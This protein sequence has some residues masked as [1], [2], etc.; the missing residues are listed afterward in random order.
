MRKTAFIVSVAFVLVTLASCGGGVKH[1]PFP[2]QPQPEPPGASIAITPASD[3]FFVQPGWAIEFRAEVTGVS[4]LSGLQWSVSGGEVLS[5]EGTTLVWRPPNVP[6]GA[7]FTITASVGGESASYEV[8]VQTILPPPWRD[9]IVLWV[10]D[11]ANESNVIMPGATVQFGYTSPEEL[12][13]PSWRASFGSFTGSAYTAPDVL[14]ATEVIVTLLN[15]GVPAASKVFLLDNEELSFQSS[16]E[17][18]YVL[19]SHEEYEGK[20][21]GSYI[22]YRGILFSLGVSAVFRYMP[23]LENWDPEPFDAVFQT[24]NLLDPFGWYLSFALTPEQYWNSLPATVDLVVGRYATM[25]DVEAGNVLWKERTG[26]ILGTMPWLEVVHTPAEL[27]LGEDY[28]VAVVASAED[29]GSLDDHTIGV[30]VHEWDFSPFDPEDIKLAVRPEP[31]SE[32]P[33][34]VVRFDE[35]QTEYGVHIVVYDLTGWYYEL[36]GGGFVPQVIISDTF[37][38]PD[39]QQRES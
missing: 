31:Y 15:Y 2:L 37:P 28:T 10:D 5:V 25:E 18:I 36:L 4:G 12:F 13:S 21:Y 23:S 39:F 9:D 3:P 27:Y 38:L 32:V 24:G 8:E 11:A 22:P 7:R 19:V 17:P 16:A 26:M 35:P 6:D 33:R 29:A 34:D 1:R 20:H 30:V 14:E